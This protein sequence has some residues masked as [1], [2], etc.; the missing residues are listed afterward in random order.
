[1]PAHIKQNKYGIWY[2]VDGFT[3]KSLRTKAKRHAELRLKQYNEGK[4]SVTSVPTVG[5]F[6]DE[7]IT[8][9]VPP[10]VRTTLARGYRQNFT[11]HILPRFRHSVLSDITTK[12]LREFQAELIGSGLSV[13][14]VRNLIDASFRALY[15]DARVEIGSELEGRDPFMDLQ[16]PRQPKTRPDPLTAEERDRIIRWYIEND[17]FYYP[18]VAW[19]F[20]TGMR[21]SETF[22]LTWADIELGR[23]TISI[24][25]SRNMGA[26]GATKTVN[27]ERI[28][29][30]DQALI[31]IL[32]LLPSRELGIEHVFV[33]K[34][35]NPMSKKWAEHSWSKPLKKL[36]IRHRKFYACRHTTITELVKAGH[37]LK[38]IADY[39]GTSVAMIEQNYCARLQ[40]SP[41]TVSR[42]NTAD[43]TSVREVFEKLAKRLTDQLS[44]NKDL[45]GEN[46]VAGPGFEPG[47]SRL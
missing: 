8:R 6:Y 19:Q 42:E 7:W 36:E 22:A 44:E 10:L 11:K 41:D 26:T 23:G 29:Q 1:M 5:K 38:A 2:L 40:L 39:V 9:K 17:F 31:D 18:L 14:T 34:T 37:N 24:N 15:R 4:F 45:D 20:H 3:N 27:S 25:K 32:K 30:I 16:W 46:L 47:T 13:K 43:S 12:E 21:P 28:I 33:G 35:G